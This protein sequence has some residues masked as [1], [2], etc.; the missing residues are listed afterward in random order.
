MNPTRSEADIPQPPLD[1]PPPLQSFAI[2]SKDCLSHNDH[3]TNQ[4]IKVLGEA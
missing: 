1:V 3:A 4:S 2:S